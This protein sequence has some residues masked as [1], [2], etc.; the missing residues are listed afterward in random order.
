M[1]I[2]LWGGMSPVAGGVVNGA[3]QVYHCLG[4]LALV[5]WNGVWGTLDIATSHGV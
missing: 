2:P 4:N 3:I 5:T 1:R